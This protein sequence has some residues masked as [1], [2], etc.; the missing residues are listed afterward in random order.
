MLVDGRAKYAFCWVYYAT[1]YKFINSLL[2]FMDIFLVVSH[3]AVYCRTRSFAFEVFGGSK[4]IMDDFVKFLSI[5]FFYQLK[6]KILK[7]S[8]YF[9]L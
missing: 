6:M 4:N 5:F 7:D 1:G 3:T 9:M 8:C 2:M